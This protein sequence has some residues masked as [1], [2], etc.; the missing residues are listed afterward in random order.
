MKNKKIIA[1]DLGLKLIVLTPRNLHRLDEI[2]KIFI[3]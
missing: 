2:F 1:K 3:N